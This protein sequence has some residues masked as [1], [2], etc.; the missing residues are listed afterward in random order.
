MLADIWGG[1]VERYMGW[2][3]DV[4][5]YMGWDDSVDSYMGWG[6][7]YMG[8]ASIIIVN[9]LNL[10]YDHLVLVQILELYTEMRQEWGRFHLGSR[11]CWH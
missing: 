5:S 2:G 7:S 10:K 11:P 3:D 9:I 1:G 6:D 4:D 8:F